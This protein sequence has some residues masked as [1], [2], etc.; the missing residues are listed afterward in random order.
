MASRLHSGCFPPPRVVSDRPWLGWKC[1]KK[2]TRSAVGS[3]VV[4]AVLSGT[5]WS[6]PA[7]APTPQDP[8]NPAWG[9]STE[10]GSVFRRTG[11]PGDQVGLVGLVHWLSRGCCCGGIGSRRRRSH[12]PGADS[13]LCTAHMPLSARSR[14][15]LLQVGLQHVLV[16]HDATGIRSMV[17]LP[18]TFDD[19]SQPPADELDSTADES[20][21]DAALR[22][23]GPHSFPRR[24]RLLDGN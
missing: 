12:S 15:A 11:R 23:A 3:L 22:D 2:P 13:L 4:L 24:G 14:V 19:F 17:L 5:S 8:P 16:G 18:P 7:A 1:W 6:S 21:D 9:Q 20:A 10:N